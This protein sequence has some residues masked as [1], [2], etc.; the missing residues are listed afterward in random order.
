V[1]L[2][3]G[4]GVGT[5]ATAVAVDS[6]SATRVAREIGV[7]VGPPSGPVWRA[8]AVPTTNTVN[9]TGATEPQAAWA[10]SSPPP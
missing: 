2:G 9:A 5:R 8:T 6:A 4:V 3:T 1:F 7:G 10:Y